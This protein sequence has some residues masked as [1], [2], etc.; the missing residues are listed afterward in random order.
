MHENA[1]SQRR[2]NIRLART[3]FAAVAFLVLALAV[4][5]SAQTEIDYDVDDDGLIEISNLA[6]L[7]MFH[8]DPFGVGDGRRGGSAY[9]SAFPHAAPNKGCPTSECGGYELVADLDLDA[10]GDGVFDEDDGYYY[11]EGWGKGIGWFPGSIYD[12]VFEGNGHTISN[13]YTNGRSGGMFSYI[14]KAATV[15]NLSL[16]DAKVLNATS[17]SGVGALA[18]WNNGDILAVHV[19]GKVHASSNSPTGLVAGENDGRVIAAY[20]SGAASAP[21]YSQGMVAGLV[22]S[23]YGTVRASYSTATVKSTYWDQSRK[24]VGGLIANG[25]PAVDSFWDTETSGITLGVRWADG[26]TSSELQ[27]PTD[28]S[29]I[30]ENWDNLNLDKNRETNDVNALW[31]FGTASDY[32]RLAFQAAPRAP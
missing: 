27:T 11:W 23:N 1:E 29:G 14:A 12:G 2:R 28:Y 7:S 30:F 17:S 20:A 9:S 15:R 32:P 22:G 18:N 5:T 16:V 4:P 25:R 6:Q 10:N 21:A 8:H 3:G 24:R 13:L 31:D 26:I 19:S